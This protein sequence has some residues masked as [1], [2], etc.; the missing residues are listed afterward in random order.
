MQFNLTLF[1][2]SRNWA[3]RQT[4]RVAVTLSE[5]Y[6]YQ[7]CSKDNQEF[8]GISRILHTSD[9]LD[10]S[11][12]AQKTPKDMQLRNFLTPFIEYLSLLLITAGSNVVS[13]IK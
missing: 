2:H 1:K 12:N 5:C 3:R 11:F 13:L 8:L 10:A 4:F 6:L 7:V 9:K